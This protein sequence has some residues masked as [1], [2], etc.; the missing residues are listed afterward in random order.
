MAKMYIFVVYT[1]KIAQI[2]DDNEKF[3]KNILG[4]NISKIKNAIPHI[5]RICHKTI[6]TSPNKFILNKKNITPFCLDRE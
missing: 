5:V 1:D 4:V 3:K 6:K 2:K